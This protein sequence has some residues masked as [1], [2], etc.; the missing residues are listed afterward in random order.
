MTVDWSNVKATDDHNKQF[1][2][3]MTQEAWMEWVQK[4]MEIRLFSTLELNKKHTTNQEMFIQANYLTSSKKSI[5]L[6]A[7]LSGATFI[8]QK[9]ALNKQ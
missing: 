5:S 3:M 1:I 7:F 2:E 8:L 6:L 4:R 9:P